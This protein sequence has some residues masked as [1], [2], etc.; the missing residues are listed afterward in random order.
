MK[1]A[2]IFPAILLALFF[3]I[4]NLVAQDN[5][6]PINTDD[7]HIALGGYSPVSYIDLNLAQRGS[8]QFKSEYNGMSYYFTSTEQKT[9]FDRNPEKYLPQFGG[10]CALGVGLGKHFRINPHKFVVTDG[11][12]YV[13]LYNLE[14]DAKGK[15]V[16][17]PKGWL[18][19]AKAN[20]ERMHG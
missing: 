3:T 8:Q 12:L 7:S 9:T 18:K 14:V 17:D 4:G 19:K 10:W 2:H 11:K 20:W 13:F 1:N 5:Y 15:W 16:Q 6:G